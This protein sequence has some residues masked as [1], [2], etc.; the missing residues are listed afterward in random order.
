MI[1]KACMLVQDEKGG[2]GGRGYER[3]VGVYCC[4]TRVSFDAL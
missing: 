4:V 3:K 2:G 1:N